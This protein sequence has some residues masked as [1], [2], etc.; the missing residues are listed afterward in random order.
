MRL[1][2]IKRVLFG[3]LVAVVSFA[4][5]GCAID[6]D[7]ESTTPTASEASNA[8]GVDGARPGAREP[9]SVE[10]LLPSLEEAAPRSAAPSVEDRSGP[11]PNPWSE[12]AGPHPNP[13][14]PTPSSGDR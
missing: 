10:G 14:T 8:P 1:S 3:V 6:T 7:D 13:W 12:Q 9:E 11:H 2:T 4:S 5:T